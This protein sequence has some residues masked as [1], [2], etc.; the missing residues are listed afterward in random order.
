LL[1]LVLTADVFDWSNNI[2]L[3]TAIHGEGITITSMLPADAFQL[4]Q[5]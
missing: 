1:V 2:N 3:I 4:E 5:L